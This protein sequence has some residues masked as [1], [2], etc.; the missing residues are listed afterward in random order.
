MKMLIVGR[1]ESYK[2]IDFIKNFDGKIIACDSVANELIDWGVMPDY[3]SWLE[4]SDASAEWIILSLI[5]RL[6]NTKVV[7]RYGQLPERISE[8]SAKHNIHF[9]GFAPPA[10][11]NNVGLFA[12]VFAQQLL[13]CKELHLIGMEHRGPEYSENWFNDMLGAFSRFWCERDVGCNMIDHSVDGRLGL[14][15]S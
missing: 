15:N 10:S 7:F 2:Q 12:I 14:P 6:K 8:L 4:T 13:R 5:P 9:K 1:G 11:V 3:I